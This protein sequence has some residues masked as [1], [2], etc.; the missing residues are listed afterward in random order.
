MAISTIIFDLGGVLVK[1]NPETCFDKLH[2]SSQDQ[3][4]ITSLLRSGH[5]FDDLDLGLYD[6]YQEVLDSIYLKYP[7]KQEILKGFFLSGFMEEYDTYEKGLSLL[8]EFKQKGYTILFLTNF[9]KDGMK[10]LKARFD[11]FSLADGI[12][13]SCDVHLLKP[14][15]RIYRLLVEKYDLFMD[16]CLFLDDRRENVEAAIKLGFNGIIYDEK[17]IDSEL[18]KYGL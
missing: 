17:T 4:F 12:V 9:S 5:L 14:D 11:F 2:Y 18:Q 15:S 8:K 6:T 1:H 3:E 13:C 7:E 16:E 10:R